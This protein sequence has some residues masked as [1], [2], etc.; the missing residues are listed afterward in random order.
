MEFSKTTRV[1]S[2]VQWQCTW[3]HVYEVISNNN[4]GLKGFSF[5][6]QFSGSKRGNEQSFQ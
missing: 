5:M 4:N 6:F 2:I 3:L 1:Y